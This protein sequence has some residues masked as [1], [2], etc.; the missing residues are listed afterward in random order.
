MF[1]ETED[2]AKAYTELRKLSFFKQLLGKDDDVVHPISEYEKSRLLRF[3]NKDYVIETSLGYKEGETIEIVEGPLVG[4][5]G[6]IKRVNRHKR[7]ALIEME[8]FGRK[9]LVNMG[10]ELLS[11]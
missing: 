9:V 7:M 2:I 6:E 11:K 8:I 1:L 4:R 3:M 10:L 5:V